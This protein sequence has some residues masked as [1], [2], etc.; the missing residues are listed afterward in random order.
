[1]I[2]TTIRRLFCKPTARSLQIG[3]CLLT[4]LLVISCLDENPRGQLTEEQAY[5]SASSLYINTVATLYNY[6]GGHADSEG[7]QGTYRGVYDYNTFTTDEAML[8][9]RGGDWYD[10]GFWQH[11]YLH[12]WTANDNELYAT[13]TY[14]YKV[15][16]LCNRSLARLDQYQSLL[17]TEQ[18]AAY[19]AE[20]RAL[21]ALFYYYLMDMFGRIPIVTSE[22]VPLSDIRQSERSEAFKF[23]VD[24]LQSAVSSLPLGRSNQEGEY[25]GRITRPVVWFLMAKLMLNAEVYLDDDWTD[26]NRPE[27]SQ[28]VFNLTDVPQGNVWETCIAYCNK[29]TDFGYRLEEDYAKNFAVHNE[30]SVENIFTIPM[31][32][33]L[34][35]NI[36]KYLFRS[37][38]YA[39]G[40]AVGMDCENGSCATLSTATTYRAHMV[41]STDPR[42]DMNFF[43]GEVT[44][45]GQPVLLQDGQPLVYY[46]FEVRLDL[47]GSEYEKT[48]GARMSKYEI[49][50]T[51]YSDGQL[52]QNDIVLFR[53]AD[54]LLMVSEACLR[55]Q[56]NL[57]ETDACLQLY[58]RVGAP[59]SYRNSNSLDQILSDRLLELMWEGWR[60]QDLIRFDRFHKPYDLRP[61]L[62]G[63]SDRHTIVFPIP[64]QAIELNNNLQQNPGY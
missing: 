40:G 43:S 24:E 47:S 13:W 7:L 62:D 54:V 15:V 8:P 6:I 22:D 18:L 2:T 11:L 58:E 29:L 35:P 63:E 39:H 28:T 17:T 27:G 34:Y 60:R 51:A 55:G 14:L 61:Q 3:G 19:K 37:F 30:A 59:T 57:P 36:F 31:D 25:Y 23:I 12:T 46:P 21:R 38:H 33:T 10:G 41:F 16:M 44:V 42:W 9:T 5:A 45:D 48:A 50:R 52:C 32:K 49:D 56:L 26:N 4:S 53:Y 20:V 64:A 1:M